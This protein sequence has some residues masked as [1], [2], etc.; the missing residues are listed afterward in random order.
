M[1]LPADL[2]ALARPRI[3]LMAAAGTVAGALVAGLTAAAPL[4]LAAGGAALLSAGCS[5]LN[6]VQERARDARM[7]RTKARPL[8]SGRMRPADGIV[9]SAVLLALSAALLAATPGGA[10]AAAFVPAVLFVYNGLYT[11]LKTR[12]PLAL[13]VGA[14]AGALPPALGFAAAGGAVLDARAVLL[15]GV[16]YAW[17]APHF[18]LFARLHRG[19]YAA[20]GFRCPPEMPGLGAGA[21]ALWMVCYGAAMLLVPA[22]GLVAAPLVKALMAGLAGLLCL[23]AWPLSRR[24]GRLGFALVNGSLALFL[25]L[26][27]AD[28]LRLAA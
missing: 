11:P 23:L 4:A 13:L 20:A 10:A 8:A 27:A 5:A 18:W 6:Q 25:C 26:L 28:A 2:T 9:F 22:F 24:E 14:V 17:Q 12:T 21:F 15:F 1:T 7:T 16:F 3:G 19:D